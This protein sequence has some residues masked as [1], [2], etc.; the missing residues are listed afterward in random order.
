MSRSA[1]KTIIVFFF[2]HNG[3]VCYNFL[4]QQQTVYQDYY[5]EVL[6]GVQES[7]Q[8][9]RLELWPDKWINRHSNTATPNAL[10]VCKFL[11]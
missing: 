6:K 10:G 1:F 7:V 2:D 9:K 11:S 8:R 4:A 5:L 3:I